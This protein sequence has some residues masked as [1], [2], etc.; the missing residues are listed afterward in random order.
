[1]TVFTLPG[2]LIP[3]ARPGWWV[4]LFAVGWTSWAFGSMLCGIALVSY[5]QATCPAELRGRVSAASRWINWGTLPLGGLAGG[6]LGTALGVHVTLWLAVVGGCLS[7][8]WL[9]LSPLRGMRDLP[10]EALQP[11]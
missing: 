3:M 4:L 10:A 11:A 8:L 1:M 5:Q 9:Y 7:G 2:L 6:A